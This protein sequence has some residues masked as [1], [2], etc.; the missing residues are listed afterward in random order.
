MF[1]YKPISVY[2]KGV[3]VGVTYER[4]N[5][6]KTHRKSNA[7][8]SVPVPSILGFVIK[9]EFLSIT[10]V[11]KVSVI[12]PAQRIKYLLI[13]YLYMLLCLGGFSTLVANKCGIPGH[14][15]RRR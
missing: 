13:L 6:I 12:C 4:F 14:F 2:M 11:L 1:R 5:S 3:L 9:D 10:T 15:V 7:K 8:I